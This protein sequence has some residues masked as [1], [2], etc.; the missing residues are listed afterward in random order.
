VREIDDPE[1]EHRRNDA[2][3]RAKFGSRFALDRTRLA[4]GLGIYVCRYPRTAGFRRGVAHPRLEIGVTLA[5]S[6]RQGRRGA[7]LDRRCFHVD[8]GVV[9]DIEYASAGPDAVTVLFACEPRRYLGVDDP[10]RLRLGSLAESEKALEEL[11][12]EVVRLRDEGKELSTEIDACFQSLV[13]KRVDASAASDTFERGRV[14]LEQHFHADLY[15]H[16]LADVAGMHPETFTRTF[17]RRVGMT[18][19][20]Y[21][22]VLRIDEASELAWQSPHASVVTIAEACGIRHMGTFHHAFKQSFGTTPSQ[23][24]TARGASVG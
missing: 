19:I 3:P 5:G 21:R 7:M 20:Q 11:A 4:S 17:K 18:P 1:R 16:H 8:P 22:N 15:V 2:P 12:R 6:W 23:H 9:H 13:A 14:E 24:R 10:V